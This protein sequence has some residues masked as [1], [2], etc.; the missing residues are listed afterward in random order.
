MN[1]NIKKSI[2]LNVEKLNLSTN[3]LIKQFNNKTYTNLQ[4]N[5]VNFKTLTDKILDMFYKIIHTEKN[6]EPN[7]LN[8]TKKY[9]IFII[10]IV[11]KLC[12]KKMFMIISAKYHSVFDN[13]RLAFERLNKDVDFLHHLSLIPLGSVIN[14]Y[15]KIE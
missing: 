12:N 10:D 14:L 3:K 13:I 15:Q 8:D 7:T 4:H 11:K 2:D 6:L 5:I 1:V 9:T